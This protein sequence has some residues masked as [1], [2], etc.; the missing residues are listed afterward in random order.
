RAFATSVSIAPSSGNGRSAMELSMMMMMQA[1]EAAREAAQ[2]A[3]GSSFVLTSPHF[4]VAVIAGVILAAAF[5]LVLTDLALAGG[6]NIVGA[7]IGP[8]D[9]PPRRDRRPQRSTQWAEGRHTRGEKEVT[10]L[11]KA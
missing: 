7:S 9:K 11:D 4:Y 10:V 2:A 6:L 1:Q 3:A 5:Q 8:D